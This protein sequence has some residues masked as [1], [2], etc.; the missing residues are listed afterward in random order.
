MSIKIALVVGIAQNGVIGFD[1]A[2]PWRLST[3]LKRFK[4]I[5]MGKPIIMGR[6]TFE[7][8]GRALPGRLN[9]VVSHS[10]YTAQGIESAGS[11]KEAIAKSKKW[12]LEHEAEEICVIG[13]GDI[14]NQSLP[15][16]DLLYITHILAEPVGD[17]IFPSLDEKQWTV[18]S[19]E[20]F[21]KS[22]KD[23]AET[24]FVIYERNSGDSDRVGH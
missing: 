16:A 3:D 12:A 7:S 19:R 11:L 1:G 8:I 15:F 10:V 5:T 20:I 13:G 17:T 2:M 24:I 22:E 9:V 23:S 18:R 21:P 6:K 14:Y 4:S